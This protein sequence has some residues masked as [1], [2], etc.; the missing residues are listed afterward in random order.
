MARVLKREEI[1]QL[2]EQGY[3]WKP[4]TLNQTKLGPHGEHPN[5]V[6]LEIRP[7]YERPV[8][9]I[10]PQEGGDDGKDKRG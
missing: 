1:L 4:A 7:G 5:L 9:L 8:I 3:T 2:K 10:P 6:Y